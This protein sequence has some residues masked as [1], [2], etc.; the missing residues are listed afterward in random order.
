ML[1]LAEREAPIDVFT[2][3]E[4][5]NN[6]FARPSLPGYIFQTGQPIGIRAVFLAAMGFTE[7][8]ATADPRPTHGRSTRWRRRLAETPPRRT[9]R[10]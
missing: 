7:E 10:D 4:M 3:A 8:E 5:M 6:P 1:P 9:P 2:R